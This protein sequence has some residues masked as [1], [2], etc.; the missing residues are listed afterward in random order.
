MKAAHRKELQTNVLAD[1]MGRLVENVRSGPKSASAVGWTLVVLILLVFGV[2]YYLQNT[3]LAE[4]S[5]RWLSLRAAASDPRT[6]A[7]ELEKFKE[8]EKGTIQA[9]I[10]R[11]QLA[12]W[13]LREGQDHYAS[14]QRDAALKSLVIARDLYEQLAR[15]PSDNPVLRQEALMGAAKAEEALAGAAA[16]GSEAQRGSLDRALKYYLELVQYNLKLLGKSVSQDAAVGVMEQLVQQQVRDLGTESD[17][18]Q[19]LTVYQRLVDYS[20]DKFKED[21][22]K[23]RDLT[24]PGR[25]AAVRAKELQQQRDQVRTFYAELNDKAT[26]KALPPEPKL[27]PP[28]QKP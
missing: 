18:D 11:F 12:R 24:Y 2:W 20:P 26:P 7:T 3:D 1:K 13:S 9:R 5:A 15:E 16:P 23:W 25:S 14:E 17:Q 19:A 22:L 4:D 6:M 8:T 27:A 10:A 28:S 21:A